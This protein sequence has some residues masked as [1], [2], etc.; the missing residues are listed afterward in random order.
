M[1]ELTR[2]DAGAE[3]L[4]AAGA[5]A[6]R[7]ILEDVDSLRRGVAQADGVI[8]CA[9]DHDF[10]NFV[11]NCEK[12]RPVIEAMGAEL[13]GTARPLVI[14]SGVG[15]G[16]PGNGEPA[17]EDMFNLGHPNS[18]I[19]AEMA[20]AALLEAGVNLLVMRLP[21]VHDRASSRP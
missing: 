2:S 18:G 11:A 21:Q 9:F 4:A 17:R 13:A 5:Q 1:L 8:H 14:T 16:D 3:R 7:G 6:H 19:A 20:G 12:D 15:M 10:S